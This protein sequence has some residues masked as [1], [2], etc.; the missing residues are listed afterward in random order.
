MSTVSEVSEERGVIYRNQSVP[1]LTELVEFVGATNK[2]LMFDIRKPPSDHPY[3]YSVTK[4]IVEDIQRAR[5]S[6]DKVVTIYI[7]VLYDWVLC[8]LKEKVV[9]VQV[10]SESVFLVK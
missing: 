9:R 4:R 6:P 10:M 1:T 7:A 8:N 5:I 3:E 2:T